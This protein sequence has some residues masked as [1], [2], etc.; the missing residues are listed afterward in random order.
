M[1]RAAHHLVQRYLLLSA[2]LVTA[3]AQTSTANLTG[4][5]GDPAGAAMAG[6]RL[7]LENSATHE[8]RESTSGGEGRYTFSQVLPGAYDLTAEATGFKTFT[9]RGI[10][11]VSGQSAAPN[12]QM[13]IGDLSQPVEAVAA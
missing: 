2:G 13:Q 8:R 9:Q 12:L 10:I 6:V 3:L 7:R 5:I 4:L 1:L 11:L